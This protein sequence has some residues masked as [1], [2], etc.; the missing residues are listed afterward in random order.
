M[1]TQQRQQRT[2]RGGA[3]GGAAVEMCEIMGPK[4]MSKSL[5]TRSWLGE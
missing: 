2:L 4:L 5:Y 1:G 3:A